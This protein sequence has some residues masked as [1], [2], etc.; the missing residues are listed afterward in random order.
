MKEEYL[1]TILEIVNTNIENAEIDLE[2]SDDDLSLIGMDSIAFIRIVVA[3][4]ETF[5]IEVPDEKLLITEMETLNK[6]LEVVILE[7]KISGKW[8]E[9]V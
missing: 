2:E 5:E 1:E 4:E 8:E 9:S 3:L 7:K 6:I